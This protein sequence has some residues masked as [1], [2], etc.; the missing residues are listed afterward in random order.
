MRES[1]GSSVG[2]AL[3]GAAGLDAAGGGDPYPFCFEAKFTGNSIRKEFNKAAIIGKVPAK[4][5]V[6]KAIFNGKNTI[7]GLIRSPGKE[8]FLAVFSNRGITIVGD[9]KGEIVKAQHISTLLCDLYES[10]EPSTV[11]TDSVMSKIEDVNLLQNLIAL[12]EGYI[13]AKSS[14]KHDAMSAV[15]KKLVKLTGR[16]RDRKF[17]VKGSLPQDEANRLCTCCGHEAVDEPDSNRSVL[18]SNQQKMDAH[19]AQARKDQ[20]DWDAGIQVKANNGTVMVVGRSRPRPTME[21]LR[22]ECHCVQMACL[23]NRGD[24]SEKDC[25]IKCINPATKERYEVVDGKCLCP[26]CQCDCR[27]AW[28]V[29]FFS[30]YRSVYSP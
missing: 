5:I 13:A 1:N 27:M 15:M 19:A 22:Q 3:P 21:L 29:S 24:V 6:A 2:V 23:T 8:A 25:I 9:F 28:S 11:Y 17:L 12:R 14:A 16:E 30:S 18:Q 10:L 4:V 26:M 7:A 20:A